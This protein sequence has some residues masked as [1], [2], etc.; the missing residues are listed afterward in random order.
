MFSH[1]YRKTS[2]RVLIHSDDP[3]KECMSLGWFPATTLFPNVTRVSEDTYEMKFYPRVTAPKKQL[4]P[5][6]YALYLALREYMNTFPS[7]EYPNTYYS[8]GVK[9][10]NTLPSRFNREKHLLESAFDAV[11]NYG[12]DMRFEISPRNISYTP[13]GKLI[14]LDCFFL[15]SK[16]KF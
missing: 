9:H 8:I 11:A 14:L 6:S 7:V 4:N 2:N 13:S 1:V 5:R 15:Q 3:V 12:D 16:R 10:L